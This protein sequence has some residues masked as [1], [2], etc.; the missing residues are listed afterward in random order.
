MGLPGFQPPAPVLI[1]FFDYRY[2]IP[3]VVGII[4]LVLLAVPLRA[5]GGVGAAD[6]AP[7]SMLTFTRGWW[8]AAPAAVLALIVIITVAA[9]VASQ[10]DALT[11]RYDSVMVDA[12][13][14]AIATTIYGWFYSVPALV[15]LAVLTAA[16]C[17]DLLLIARPPLGEDR[18]LDVRTRR[19]RTRN[20]LTAATAA[21]LL[22]L[23]AVFGSL[24]ATA[25]VQG[26]FATSEGPVF[27]WS[28][29]AGFQAAFTVAAYAASVGGVALWATVALSAVPARGH[30]LVPAAA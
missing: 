15:A 2:T 7:R 28:P 25:S 17:V 22:H 19:T 29:I 4:A 23:A 16:V 30:A 11:G 13:V 12:G 20:V 10:P 14:A 5:R 24:S 3:L 6:L 27:L 9:G 8:F 26:E 1:W 21:M 18:E